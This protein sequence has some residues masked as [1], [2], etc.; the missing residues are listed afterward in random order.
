MTVPIGSTH[1]AGSGLRRAAGGGCGM[2]TDKYLCL[3]P[4]H[5]WCRCVRPRGHV[6]GCDCLFPGGGA[7]TEL[8]SA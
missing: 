3:A 8:D 7:G 5:T 6:G 1:P 4:M 2:P